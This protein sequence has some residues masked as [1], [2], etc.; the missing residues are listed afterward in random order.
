V[1]VALKPVAGVDLDAA[2]EQFTEIYRAYADR[3]Y[4]FIWRR[5]DLREAAL[6]EDLTSETFIEL[7]RRYML[8]GRAAQV[9]KPY[10]LLCVMARNQIGQHFTRFSNRERSLDFAD[11]VNTP[12]VANGHGYALERPDLASLVRELDTAMDAMRDASK[13]WRD[14]HKTSY[15]LRSQL[16]EGA[17]EAWGALYQ[18]AK[19]EL[20]ARLTEVEAQEDTTLGVFRSACANV[21][22]LR[23]ELESVAGPN[24]RS[25]LGLPAHPEITAFKAG[26][27]RNDRSVTHCPAGHLMDLHNTHFAENGARDCRACRHQQYTARRTSPAAKNVSPVNDSN[28]AHARALLADPENADLALNVIADRAGI[29]VGCMR[30]AIPD[31]DVIRPKSRAGACADKVLEAARSLLLDPDGTLGLHEIAAAAGISYKTLKRHLSK[32][33]EV[34]QQRLADQRITP[35]A[36]DAARGLLLDPQSTLTIHEIARTTGIADA[37]LRKRLPAEIERCQQKLRGH[38]EQL[39]ERVR[40]QLLDPECQ[41]SILAIAKAHGTTDRWIQRNFPD[42]L[43]ARKDRKTSLVGAG[44]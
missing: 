44:R 5:L 40:A 2:T 31:M 23:A 26:A 32:E 43:A 10:G 28:V 42:E 15:H 18:G 29:S 1:T 11:P 7:W 41:D 25:S 13:A 22:R 9:T 34:C 38:K 36:L 6:A 37:S 27:Y 3:L 19:N 16:G 4:S 8:T 14:M 17:G 33:A 35:A 21:G 12:I 30:R 24:W 20:R 39:R